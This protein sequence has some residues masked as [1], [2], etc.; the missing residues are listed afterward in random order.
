M[1]SVPSKDLDKISR[2]PK[3][4]SALVSSPPLTLLGHV[5]EVA[6]RH[7]A[8]GWLLAVHAH[9][10]APH[11]VHHVALAVLYELLADHAALLLML[12][13]A[14]AL[15]AGLWVLWQVA[16]LVGLPRP[17]VGAQGLLGGGRDGR[18][19]KPRASWRTQQGFSYTATI[20]YNIDDLDRMQR[21][22]FTCK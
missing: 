16:S 6:C 12:Q 10:A 13:H 2:K 18:W 15:Q 17:Q 20:H 19:S 1:I 3:E 7:H 21:F 5:L 8:R 4:R 22:F 14:H 11:P 9:F